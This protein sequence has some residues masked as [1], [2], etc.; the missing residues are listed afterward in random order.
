VSRDRQESLEVTSEGFLLRVP[1]FL[2]LL[3]LFAVL[4][5]ELPEF[6]YGEDLLSPFRF[7]A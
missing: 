5:V 6:L 7:M 3:L 4:V 2:R 1:P